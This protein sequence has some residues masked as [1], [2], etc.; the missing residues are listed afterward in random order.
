MR[1]HCVIQTLRGRDWGKLPK[2]QGKGWTSRNPC[3]SEDLWRSRSFTIQRSVKTHRTTKLNLR[4]RACNAY[5]PLLAVRTSACPVCK[6]ALRGMKKEHERHV[7]CKFHRWLPICFFMGLDIGT[8]HLGIGGCPERL[9]SPKTAGLDS[10]F[11]FRSS[12]VPGPFFWRKW[13]KRNSDVLRIGTQNIF[14]RLYM[15]T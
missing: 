1:H 7:H 13:Q 11:G 9:S 5:Y 6:S 2:Q 14:H 10:A 3:S 8:A 4:C 12:E 15:C